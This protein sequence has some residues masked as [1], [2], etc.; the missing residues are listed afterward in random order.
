MADEAT[1]VAAPAS[2]Q[3]APAAASPATPAPVDPRAAALE[4]FKLAETAP[5]AP[6]DAGTAA[7]AS[8]DPAASPEAVAPKADEAKPQEPPPQQDER[9]SRGF[10]KLANQ[11]AALLA[12]EQNLTKR[13]TDLKTYDDL[14]AKIASDPAAVLDLLGASSPQ[15]ALERVAEA[16]MA[17]N[18]T[19]PAKT[20]E[21]RVAELERQQAERDRLAAD[22]ET[23]QQ[24]ALRQAA[25][26][27]AVGIVTRTLQVPGVAEQFATINA[28]GEHRQVF[29]TLQAYVEKHKIPKEQVT[30]DLVKV[31]AAEVEAALVEEYS[32]LVVKVPHIAARVTPPREQPAPPG[33]RTADGANGSS[34]TT[35]AGSALNGAPPHQPP[36]RR[37]PEELR[38]EAL[39]HFQ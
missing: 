2:A 26:E 20:A 39:K 36:R 12:R 4:L 28:L 35:L 5:K 25:I 18:G 6:T 1:P 14:R 15:E 38:A 11:K 22:R 33:Q 24:E 21:E 8:T 30:T 34:S 9:L 32:G 17:R 29:D 19:A 7:P 3:A 16:Y 37:T 31:V 23:Q 13:E 27:Q 10:A